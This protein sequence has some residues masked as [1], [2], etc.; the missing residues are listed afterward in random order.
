MRFEGNQVSNMDSDDSHGPAID[1]TFFRNW[2]TGVRTPFT[3]YI[4][5]VVINDAENLPG[6]N[7][8][9]R[10]YWMAFVGNVLGASGVTTFDA[11]TP[12]VQALNRQ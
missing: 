12:F 6:G 11:G 9:L 3:D 2:A 8:P 1:H 10:A 7:A 4:S 5:D